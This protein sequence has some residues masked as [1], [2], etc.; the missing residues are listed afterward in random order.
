MLRKLCKV[1]LSMKQYNLNQTK[2]YKY[3]IVDL[4]DIVS[5]V[6]YR[7]KKDENLYNSINI[8]ALFYISTL[9]LHKLK[10]QF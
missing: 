1:R 4:K 9:S 5:R 10:L 8:N 7:N 2:E 3:K 6:C